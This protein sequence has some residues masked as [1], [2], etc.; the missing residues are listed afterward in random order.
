MAAVLGDQQLRQIKTGEYAKQ[1]FARLKERIG[2]W[3]DRPFTPP[4]RD[5]I[6][7]WRLKGAKIETRQTRDDKRLKYQ[8]RLIG[9]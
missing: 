2:K 7:R 1:V 4:Y 8:D 9:G 6:R 3:V 5:V